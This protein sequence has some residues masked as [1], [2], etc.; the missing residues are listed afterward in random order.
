M[1]TSNGIFGE[2]EISFELKPWMFSMSQGLIV[3]KVL[4]VNLKAVTMF[5]RWVK[6]AAVLTKHL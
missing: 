1:K 4:V 6:A 5:S 3:V 2:K